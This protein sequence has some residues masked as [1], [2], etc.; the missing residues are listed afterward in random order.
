M[1]NLVK[2]FGQIVIDLSDWIVFFRSNKIS[3]V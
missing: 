3:N 2:I 1:M